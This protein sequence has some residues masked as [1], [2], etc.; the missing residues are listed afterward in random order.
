M[1]ID[2]VLGA[3]LLPQVGHGRV[4][5]HLVGPVG[6]V[7]QRT[8]VFRRQQALDLGLGGGAQ[9]PLGQ[10]GDH[11][12]PQRPPRQRRRDQQAGEHGEG[13]TADETHAGDSG[14]G[15]RSQSATPVLRCFVALGAVPRPVHPAASR[16]SGRRAGM[17]VK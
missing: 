17:A 5:L 10:F 16:G 1:E 12:V 15:A 6:H 7:G 8:G 3:G 9:V 13:G 14:D 4:I 2:V 11:A